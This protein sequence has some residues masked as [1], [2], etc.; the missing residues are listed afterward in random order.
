[1]RP[2]NFFPLDISE[3]EA[4]KLQMKLSSQ[5]QQNDNFSDIRCV[6]GVDVAY[7]KDGDRLVASVVV[8]NALTLQVVETV[9][10]EDIAI[11]PYIVPER[12]PCIFTAESII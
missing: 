3:C 11:F 9:V 4:F 10:V 1:M 6:A 2:R 5:V 12:K 8:L 7:Q